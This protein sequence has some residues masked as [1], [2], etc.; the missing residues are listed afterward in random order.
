MT[1]PRLHSFGMSSGVPPVN[2]VF[3][4]VGGHQG[5]AYYYF[6]HFGAGSWRVSGISAWEADAGASWFTAFSSLCL[7]GGLAFQASGGR[8]AAPFLALLACCAGSLRPVLS[9]LFGEAL[10]GAVR[11]AS[12]F[13][14]WSSRRVGAPITWRLPAALCSPSC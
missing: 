14:G 5:V 4:E 6:W 9:A 7:M 12:G 3:A 2:P 8:R 1:T 10:D 13:A 11:P